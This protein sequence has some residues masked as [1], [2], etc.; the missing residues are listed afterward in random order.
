MNLLFTCK[1]VCLYE[2]V[3]AGSCGGQNAGSPGIT[4]DPEMSKDVLELQLSSL[5]N[6]VSM[7][8]F[9]SITVSSRG[10]S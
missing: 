5:K 4:G 10:V 8:N 9:W 1:Y 7:F 6:A 3:S 2:N